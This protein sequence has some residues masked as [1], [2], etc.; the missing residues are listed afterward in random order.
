[1]RKST[2]KDERA[3]RIRFAKTLLLKRGIADAED[4]GKLIDKDLM[5]KFNIADARTARTIVCKAQAD[6][7]GD[8]ANEILGRYPEK[9]VLRHGDVIELLRSVGG[10]I[11]DS[12]SYLVVFNGRQVWITSESSDDFLVRK[13]EHDVDGIRG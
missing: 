5:R 4:A 9:L 13:I 11:V 10:E 6:L 8:A 7:R 1:M 3:E 12:E 2:T